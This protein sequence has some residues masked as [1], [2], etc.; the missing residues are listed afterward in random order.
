V[1]V[2]ATAMRIVITGGAG[3]IGSNIADAF[4]VQGHEVTVL[5]NLS[6]GRPDNVP[7]EAR[8]V[9]IDICSPEVRGVL[10][11]LRPD[12]L[13]HHAAQIDVRRSV[14]DPAFDAEVN[15]VG[16]IRLL[17]ICRAIGTR[18]ILFA[19]TGG[20]IYGEQD[21]FPA[22]EAHP[23]RPVSPY[24]VAKLSVEHYLH[25]Y[26]VEHGFRATCLRYANVYGPRQNPHGE[27]GVVAIF[28]SKILRGEPAVINGNGE[29]TRD[30]VFVGDV[31]R[32]NVAALQHDLVGAYNVGT[33][34]ET[35][36]NDLYEAIRKAAGSSERAK[37]APAKPGEQQRSCLDSS[38]LTQA[39]G[40]KASVGLA[41]GIGKTVEF[42]R[43]TAPTV[44]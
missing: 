27:A 7:R 6:S 3:F 31:V 28:G 35:S 4:V 29:Q 12:V 33:G 43:I 36:V 14:S 38:R 22:T 18:R 25:Y 16:S 17:E 34:I 24:G 8:L 21:F 10:E 32:A 39:C 13:C 15:V 2:E 30:F 37:H 42:F 1:A 5:D 41:E 40:W 44:S 26:T 9:K 19:S 20:A 23:A 11:E